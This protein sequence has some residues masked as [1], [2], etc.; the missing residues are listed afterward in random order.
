MKRRLDV[1]TPLKTSPRV[2][3][4]FVVSAMI[5][6]QVSSYVDTGLG[7]TKYRNKIIINRMRK[8]SMADPR[9][10]SCYR[11]IILARVAYKPYCNIFSER[12]AQWV[13]ILNC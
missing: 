3:S 2:I 10:P 9:D 8:S 13:D 11:G 5:L 7:C 4:T 12:L 1:N 6:L